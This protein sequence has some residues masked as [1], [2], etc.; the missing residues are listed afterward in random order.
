MQNDMKLMALAALAAMLLTTG[1]NNKGKT[2]PAKDKDSAATVIDSIIEENDTTPMPMFLM[3]NDGQYMQVLYWSLLDEPQKDGD[4][5]TYYEESHQAWALQEMLRRNAAKYTNM[6]MDGKFTKIKFVD[7]VL[8]DPDG[9]TP[10][11]GE[12]H[13]KEI[14]SLCARFDFANPKDKKVNEYGYIECGSV[15]VTDSYLKS[16]RLLTLKP[17]ESEWDKP[18]PLPDFAVR[19]LAKKYGMEIE[20]HQLTAIISDSI[21]WGHLQF[22][23]EYK[24]APKDPDDKDRRSALALDVLVSGDKVYAHEAIGYYD[25]QYGPTWNADDDG[26]YVGCY[27]MAAFEGAK[28][29]EL[30]FGRDAPESSAVGMFYARSGQLIQHTYETYHNLIDETI[31]VW[32][33]DIAEM[34]R[35]FLEQDPGEHKHFKLTKYAH[36]YLDYEHNWIWMRDSTDQY[37]AFFVQQDGKFTLIAVETP[38]LKPSTMEAGDI[39]YLQ[40]SGSAGGPSTYREVYAFKGGK[41]TERFTALSIYNEVDES[42]LNGKTLSKEQAETYIA[43]LPAANPI[44]AYFTD[45]EE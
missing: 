23:G 37:G 45:I 8:K 32:K 14:P 25:E 28:G 19:Q 17:V 3:R 5:D 7:E 21:A 27:L 38:R 6:L 33:K 16:R 40:L 12:V 30:C 43:K 24:N 13:R 36:F 41:Q 2:A 35:L 18:K 20:R 15:I 39:S 11:I 44:N 22:K 31:P 9:N 34:R 26:Q 1:C 4:N 42:S 29:L 10:S